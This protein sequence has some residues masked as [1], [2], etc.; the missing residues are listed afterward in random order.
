[1]PGMRTILCVDDDRDFLDMER[2]ILAGGGYR[3]ACFSDPAS[4]LAAMNA[5]AEIP[6]LVVTDLMMSALDS[7]FT[8]AR[9]LKD[10]P[11]FAKV[12]VIIVTAVS[13]QKGFDFTPKGAGDLLAMGAAAFFDKPVAP[14]ALLAKVKELIG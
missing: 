9:A 11:R 8:L 13:R 1:M 10:D 14:Q 6:D 12:P 2:R 5:A 7:G 3:V 4:A